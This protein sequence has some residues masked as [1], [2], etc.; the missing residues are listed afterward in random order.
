MKFDGT[1]IEKVTFDG[2]E[3]ETVIMDGT[4]VFEAVPPELVVLEGKW[5]DS[6]RTGIIDSADTNYVTAES[7]Y[8]DA[9]LWYNKTSKTETTVISLDLKKFSKAV[10]EYGVG[11]YNTIGGNTGSTKINGSGITASS[12]TVTNSGNVTLTAECSCA[13]NESF[14]AAYI[15]VTKITMYK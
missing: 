13:S 11:Y 12:I 6:T 15:Y 14:V 3:I 1:E 10:I 2:N 9:E 7:N 5:F 8:A 4:V